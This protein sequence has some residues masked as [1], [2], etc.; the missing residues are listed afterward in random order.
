MQQQAKQEADVADV[1]GWNQA[2]R[3][4][5]AYHEPERMAREMRVAVQQIQLSGEPIRAPSKRTIR[6]ALKA[7]RAAR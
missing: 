3:T 4:A 5:L 6:H 2:Y 7:V 1:E